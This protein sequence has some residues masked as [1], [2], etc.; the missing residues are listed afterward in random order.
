[1][2]IKNIESKSKTEKEALA[3]KDLPKQQAEKKNILDIIQGNKVWQVGITVFTIWALHSMSIVYSFHTNRQMFP[4]LERANPIGI[5]IAAL[6]APC[7]E[8]YKR[9]FD[10][11]FYGYFERILN[12][13]KY[14]NDE[15]KERRTKKIVK[16]ARGL[17]YYTTTSLF[18]F[19]AFRDQSFWP[20]WIGG[21][22]TCPD[23]YT[24]APDHFHIPYGNEFYLTQLGYHMWSFVEHFIR[25][26]GEATYWEMNFH[27]A[28][29]VF[30]ISYSFLLGE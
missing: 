27:H 4:T 19:F 1:M 14:S 11:L 2:G 25:R 20:T 26:K 24:N 17:I 15:E 18:A 12:P 6:I 22:N 8:A 10:Y 7:F 9:L 28:L 30:L 3:A 5:L 21:S 13:S 16:Y 29:T 23:I